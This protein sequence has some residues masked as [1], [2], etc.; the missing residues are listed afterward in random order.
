MTLS[1]LKMMLK[2]FISLL[3]FCAAPAFAAADEGGIDRQLPVQLEAD[4]LSYDRDT[5]I[6]HASGA[7]SLIQGDLHLQTDD[8]WWNQRTGEVD[9]RGAV[10]LISPDEELAGQQARYNLNQGT[11]V[12]EDGYFFLREENL[13]VRG[14]TIERRGEVDYRIRRGTYTTC[15]G[16]VPAWKFGAER[17]DLTLGGY[18]RARHT[19]FYL[20]DVPALYFPYMIYPAKTER[21]SGLLIPGVGYSDKRGF[22]YGAAYYQVLGINQ[23]ATLYLD[24]LSRMGI[25][26]GIEYRYIFGREN[27]GEARFYHIDVDRVEDLVV[28][29]E[30]YAV[31]W[32][33]SGYLPGAVRMV[34][35][36]EY[37]NDDEYFKD[38]G[39]IAEEY[40]KDRAES[41][42]SL[43]RSWGGFSLVGQLKYIKNLEV[44]TDR[45]LQLLPR[46]N[47]DLSRKRVAATP[48][49]YAL[50]SEYTHFWRREGLQGERYMVRPRLAADLSL[51]RYFSLAPELA[52]RQRFYWGLDGDAAAEAD[53][54]RL[55]EGSYEFR[56]R[57]TSTRL[58]RIF[59][60]PGH[61][62]GRMR[63]T[64]E[65]EILYS[66]IPEFEQDDLPRFDSY[67]RIA[68]EN[69]LEYA[70]VQKLRLRFEHP[71]GRRTYRDLL[72]LRLSLIHELNP[73]SSDEELRNARAE[74]TLR[75]LDWLVLTG[76]ATY[77]PVLDEWPKTAAS[78]ALRDNSENALR[79]SYREDTA[80]DLEYGRVDLSL[81]VLRPVYLRYQ[82]RYD[83]IESE[84]LEQVVGLEYRHQCWSAQLLWRDHED[85]RSVMLTFTMRGIGSV[86]GVGGSLGGM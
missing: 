36:V 32:Q 58:Q 84:P 64:L 43:S 60:L 18:A 52:Y 65:P 19:V 86:G 15:D 37:V 71:E 48:F 8:L 13:H 23:D 3:L 17:V 9:A 70:L 49:S 63:H 12:V 14:E 39:E 5:G 31:Q 85:D 61:S 47:A 74:L 28:D 40:N 81:A 59:N 67:D 53:D 7:V 75:P 10:R 11:G 44:E 56:T 29:E 6:Y 26:K 27:A 33:H 42:F 16:Q 41:V 20:K 22:Q 51:L 50:E 72:Y 1:G 82:Q 24:Y 78:V 35:D 38:F 54:Y 62:A 4:Q 21:E 77:D 45:T 57:L 30:R 34:A 73:E 76:D 66:Y 68:A 79:I 2:L 69:Q 83:F 55:R 80:S 46:I 25:G